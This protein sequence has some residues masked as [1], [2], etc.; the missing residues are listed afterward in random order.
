MLYA[1][2][3]LYLHLMFV[4]TAVPIAKQYSNDKYPTIEPHASI[5]PRDGTF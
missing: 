1:D 2:D 3:S 5:L 4:R